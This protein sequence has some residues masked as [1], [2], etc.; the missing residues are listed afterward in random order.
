MI[1]RQKLGF[2]LFVFGTLWIML[3]GALLAALDADAATPPCC[4]SK[5]CKQQHH[6]C[7]KPKH[8]TQTTPFPDEDWAKWQAGY[9]EEYFLG[10]LPNVEVHWADLGA[11]KDMGF[12]MQRGKGYEILID[13]AT[14][15]TGRQA[16]ETLLHEDCH[17]ATWDKAFDDDSIEFQNCMVRLAN[18]GAFKG[19]W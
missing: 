9:N 16:R 13:R 1:T 8:K 4:S 12:T 11:L 3:T 10:Q 17:V 15:P 2:W 18:Q 6:N 7:I 19:V 5:V 14:H